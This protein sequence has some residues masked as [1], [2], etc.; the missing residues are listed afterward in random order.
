VVRLWKQRPGKEAEVVDGCLSQVSRAAERVVRC[1][2]AATE[3]TVGQIHVAQHTI[4]ADVKAVKSGV[5]DIQA[6]I[7]DGVTRLESR[8]F[9][10]GQQKHLETVAEKMMDQF[11]RGIRDH[12]AGRYQQAYFDAFGEWST[13]RQR[14]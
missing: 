5:D 4:S 1:S 2:R 6:A 7:V 3:R 10:A 12:D 9:G 13:S 11:L 8:L 14:G